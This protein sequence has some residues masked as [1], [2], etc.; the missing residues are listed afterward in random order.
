MTKTEPTQSDNKDQLTET[1]VKTRPQDYVCEENKQSNK[2]YGASMIHKYGGD[3]F[4]QVENTAEDS[5]YAAYKRNIDY[6]AEYRGND[7]DDSDLDESHGYQKPTY[8]VSD[9]K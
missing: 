5:A 4:Y 3:W 7:Y 1:P 9:E 8:I 6:E 2:I